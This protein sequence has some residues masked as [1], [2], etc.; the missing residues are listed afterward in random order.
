MPASPSATIPASHQD[1]LRKKAVAH[2]ACHLNDGSIL[3]NPVWCA[4]E[5]DAVLINSAEGRLKDRAMRRNPQ[6]TLCISDPDNPFRY[7]EI[8][9]RVEN[10]TTN[11]ADAAIDRLAQKYLGVDTYPNRRP[12]EVRVS[13]RIRPDKVVAF[14]R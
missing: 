2:L 11:G 3:V 13:Y 10:V 8:R 5:G 9:G 14:G 1:L 6:V 4:E 7:L 12:G